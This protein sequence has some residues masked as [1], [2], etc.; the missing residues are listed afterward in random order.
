MR[1][2]LS[3]FI[4]ACNMFFLFASSEAL[5]EALYFLEDNDG[6]VTTIY[7]AFCLGDDCTLKA[8][9]VRNKSASIKCA[10]DTTEVY[11][12][13]PAKKIGD[14]WVTTSSQGACGYVSTFH[15]SKSGMV[16][17]RTAPQQKKSELCRVFP[18]EVYKMKPIKSI[19]EVAINISGCNS[20]RVLDL[21]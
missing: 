21:Q 9:S 12:W 10:I 16:Q 5:A 19:A 15:L 3:R 8:I 2:W 17:T 18:P 6:K 4:F 1:N 13:G 7:K 20:F 11:S 14:A